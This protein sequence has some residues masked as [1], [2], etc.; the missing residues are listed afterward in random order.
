MIYSLED[1]YKASK[2]IKKG[3]VVL[4][5]PL[6]KISFK[7]RVIAAWSVFTSKAIAV[8]WYD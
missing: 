6:N 4:S 5:K 2:I 1:I 7:N 3:V 8:R